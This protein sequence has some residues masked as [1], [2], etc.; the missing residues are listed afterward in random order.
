MENQVQAKKKKPGR[1]VPPQSPSSSMERPSLSQM[2]Y[3]DQSS[4]MMKDYAG[5]PKMVN[6]S[7]PSFKS[8]PALRDTKINKNASQSLLLNEF[9][10][11]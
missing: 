9:L 8:P 11:D 6:T 4:S 5:K 1:S 3:L 7:I 2:R 10:D